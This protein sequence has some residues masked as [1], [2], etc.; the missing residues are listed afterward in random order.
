MPLPDWSPFQ[1]A[2]DVLLADELTA[3]VVPAWLERWSQLQG[4]LQEMSGRANRTYFE[5]TLDTQ[6]EALV[7]HLIEQVIPKW[8]LADNALDHK[9]LAVEGYVPD[10]QTELFLR[11][12]RVSAQIFRPENVPIEAELDRLENEYS[13]IVGGLMVTLDGEELTV[14]KAHQRLL[15]VNRDRRESAWRAVHAATLAVREELNDLFLKILPL[16]RALA[17]NAGL[18]NFRDL[19]WLRNQR[20]DYSPDDCWTLHSSIL[21]AVV[22]LAL[23]LMRKRQV[24]LGLEAVRPWDTVVDPLALAPLQP[25]AHVLELEE[26]S[27]RMLGQLEPLFAKQFASLRDGFLDLESRKGKS[28]GGYC[29]YFPVSRRPYIFMN[30]V[31]THNDVQTLL[32]E[33]GHAIHAI[34]SAD[35]QTLIWN[36]HGPMEFCE[37]A[38]MGMEMLGQPYLERANGGFYSPNDANRARREHLQGTVDFLPYMSVVDAFQ[39]WLYADAPETITS[40]D[41]DA[42][43][44]ELYQKF[45]P[46]EDWTGLEVVRAT[47]WQRKQHIFTSPLYYVE[48][49]IA[50]LGALQLWQN[51]K[52]DRVG[53]VQK[54]RESLRLGKTRGLRDLF[55]AAGLKLA[56]DAETI[57]ELMRLVS[58]ELES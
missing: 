34:E 48:Y 12:V 22:P 43:W 41:L 19:M 10:A 16:R 39:Q 18:A 47:G 15:E 55:E 51:A 52:F 40:G 4:Q 46:G 35:A 45:S 21:K 6:A 57:G 33:V 25:F 23:E 29:D 14:P 38:A 11:S 42:K 44:D 37:V 13:K 1:A 24:S 2:Y 20:F 53:T 54:F 8:K 27:Q 3:A 49:G 56:F 31:G 50:Q 36:L 58:A 7:N 17:H 32:H 28:P 26:V 9:L 5:N 30:A